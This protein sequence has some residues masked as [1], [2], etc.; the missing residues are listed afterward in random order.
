MSANSLAS[1]N[2][3]KDLIPWKSSACML[4]S[5]G[6]SIE[7]QVEGQ[8]LK[9]IRGDK[10]SPSSQGYICQKA[11]RL[12]HYQN[13]SERLTKPL[14]KNSKG[15]FEEVEWEVV[16]AEIGKKM[17]AIK[18]EHGGNAFAY[19]GGGGQGNHLGGTYSASLTGAL[20]TPYI[21][22]ALAQE[23]TGDFWLNGKLF[24]RQS[25]YPAE[26]MEHADYVL[27]LGANPWAA[28]GVPK[29]RDVLKEYKKNPERTM[30][31]VDPRLTE[32]AKMAD[33][34]LPVKPGRDAF[35]LSA[36]ISIILQEGLEDKA[37][38]EKHTQGFESVKQKFI[39]VP[40]AEYAKLSGIE[41][42]L[43]KQVA[44][45][46]ASAKTATVQADLGI[47]QSLH[48]TLNSYLEKVLFL[49]TGNFNKEGGNHLISQFAPVLAHS[50]EPEE[51]GVATKVTGMRAISKMFP[52]NVLP[53]EINSDHPERI[54]A[55]VVDSAN[56][57]MSGADSQAY[58]KAFKSLELSV[59]IDVAMTET[60]RAA[61]YVLPA[62]SQFEKAES[63]F[64]VYG[65]PT[66]H[67]HL[68]KPIV[69]PLGDTLPEAEIY[70]RLVVSLGAIPDRFPVLE[71]I[72]KLDRK[73]Q[74]AKLFPLALAATLKANPKWVP[75]VAVI[76]YATLGKALPK[77]MAS[78]ATLWGICQFYAMRYG[79]QVAA[80]GI[81]GKGYA[82]GNNLFNRILES[83]RPVEIATFDYADTWKMLKTED[84]KV[85]LHIPEMNTALDELVY[86]AKTLQAESSNQE[87]PFTLMAGERRSYNANQIFRT[88]DWRKTEKEGAMR[89]HPQ[90]L[91]SL[92]LEDGGKALCRSVAGQIEVT[93]MSDDSVQEGMVTLPHGYG[94]LYT[95]EQGELKQ[96]G[97]AINELTSLDHCDAIAKT[98]F[99]KNVAVAVE[100]I[101]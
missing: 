78:A 89:I 65:F 26:G 79:K 14:R 35:L 41:V 61:D 95:D 30:V 18:K 63:V 73:Y 98:P 72:A 53:L 2:K 62:S 59:V 40:V 55:V 67:F 88:P 69:K 80:T 1:P 31:V 37:F 28:H 76:L 46:F 34:H 7:V 90:D 42:A 12:D 3:P 22:S 68:R 54:R 60:A 52:P 64:F 29:T 86:E 11:A 77:D 25:C 57:V 47:Q 19:Y 100:A 81:E 84:K 43:I 36:L 10:A 15:E 58:R 56:P 74:S 94:M 20:G 49:I 70:R 82:I 6:C 92:S 38:L 44:I 33:L 32:T 87:Y 66:A 85:H 96:D 48:S 17:S 27:V 51:G 23:K 50:K 71:R 16:I 5:I 9:K 91:L 83:D 99:H 93:L 39:S 101:A 97:P 45:G 24:G 75:Y 13:H 8:S 4:C 21:Y